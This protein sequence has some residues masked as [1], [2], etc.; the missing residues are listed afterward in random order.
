MGG[1]AVLEKLDR[2]LGTPD[3]VWIEVSVKTA[4]RP[5]ATGEVAQMI[6]NLAEFGRWNIVLHAE[7]V[8]SVP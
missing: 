5:L 3:R 1:E 8:Q 6:V 7:S 2:E 4:T